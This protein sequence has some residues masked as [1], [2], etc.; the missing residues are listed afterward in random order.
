MTD[1]GA[2]LPFD[3]TAID[4]V[5]LDVGGVL[6]VPDHGLIGHALTAAGIDH[7]RSRFLD[8]HYRAMAEVDRARSHPEVLTDYTGAFLR[9]GWS[10]AR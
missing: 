9:W 7:D 5:S 6:L 10:T 2:P 1:A 4:A 3:R 8:G